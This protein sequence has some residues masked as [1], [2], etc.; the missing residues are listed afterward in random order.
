MKHVVGFSGGIDSQACA[1]W[2]LNRENPD[3]VILLNSNVGGHEHPI[4]TEFIHWYSENV[5]PVQIV[6]P[7]VADLG[8]VGM[9]GRGK[10]SEERS[11]FQDTDKMDFALM[12]KIKGR[13]PSSKAQFC[14]TYLKLAPSHRWMK[15]NLHGVKWIRYSGVRR[16]ESDRRKNAR[17]SGWDDYFGCELLQPIF[18]WS[19]EMCFEYVRSHGEE[20]NE[21]Y[22]LGFSRIGCAPCVNANKR[23]VFEWNRRFPEMID[24]VRDWE[25]RVG[26]TFFPP[27]VPG[28]EINWID[29]VVKWSKTTYGGK[30]TSLEVLWTPA[31]CDSQYGLCE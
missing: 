5:H 20:F 19:K 22:K 30:Q 8:R 1:R 7:I 21:L 27:V 14:T 4:T 17:P 29:D 23:D 26:R 12:A 3:D 10:T 13:F 18:D 31:A 28:M 15:K 24:K 6:E 16:S 9:S 2:V 11:K 25:S